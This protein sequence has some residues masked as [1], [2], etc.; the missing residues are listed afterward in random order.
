M[1][2]HQPPWRVAVALAALVGF[3]LALAMVALS[4]DAARAQ[5]AGAPKP[6]GK[7][8]QPVT[9]PPYFA[10]ECADCHGSDGAGSGSKH[11]SFIPEPANLTL[12]KD[13]PSMMVSIVRNGIQGTA[14]DAHRDFT[15]ERQKEV[16]DF[17]SQMPT[18]MQRQ[19]DWPYVYLGQ[20][21]VPPDKWTTPA[22]VPPDMGRAIFVTSCSGC[23]GING[24]GMTDDR[25]NPHIW[26][27]PADFH[28][29]N[30]EIGR[31]YD[32]ISNGRPGTMMPAFR[33]K[34]TTEEARWALAVYVSGLYDP[35]S[36]A[37]IPTGKKA[38]YKN[39]YT[40]SDQKVVSQGRRVA[41]LFCEYCHGSGMAGTW[42]APDLTDRKWYVGGGTDNAL[43]LIVSNGI[44]GVLMPPNKALPES[45]RWAVITYL[46]H[47]GGLPEPMESLMKKGGRD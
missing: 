13:S 40:P 12:V 21:N 33:P 41:T 43:F 2:R 36:T 26:P 19:W 34:L 22:S 8:G 39:P 32:I 47:G 31:L 14:M 23:H 45:D 9:V 1:T 15:P 27:K 35:N 11:T 3:A 44:P 7:S 46:R 38:A 17:L 25:D 4:P 18:N 20:N 37:T 10:K 6:I 5:H 16:M 29:R 24:D 28:A 30:S 42:E